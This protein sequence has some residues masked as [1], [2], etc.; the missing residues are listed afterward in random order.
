MSAFLSVLRGQPAPHIPVWFMRQAGRYLPEYRALRA[1]TT[2]FLSFC[3]DSPRAAEATLQPLRRFDLDAAII[4]SDILVI[5]DALGQRVTFDVGH[6]PRLDPVADFAALAFRSHHLAPV[7]AAIQ[8]VRAALP[9]EKAL[10][11][12]AGSPFTLLA[13]MIEGQGSKTFDR[14]LHFLYARPEEA[15]SLRHLLEDTIMA[16]LSAQIQAGADA[17]QLFD[18]WAG[19][20][21]APL[22]HDWVIL[23]H[24]RIV[25]ALRVRHPSIPIVCFPRGSGVKVVDFVKT[26]QPDGISIDTSTPMAWAVEVLPETVTLQGNLDPALLCAGGAELDHAVAALKKIC[27]GR[28]WI[29]NL[30]HGV[31]PPTPPAH[32]GRVIDGLRKDC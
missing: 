17:V 12:F 23:P 13:Y 30:G 14:A 32:V 2:D 4:F 6:G 3:Y 5:P 10:I 20:V 8:A 31:L 18:S 19:M 1:E 15:A 24:Q 11:G 21:P 25:S 22:Y 29:M 27:A 16:H 26:V 9:P 7:Y 28:R